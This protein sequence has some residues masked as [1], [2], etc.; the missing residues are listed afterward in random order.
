[1]F[2]THGIEEIRFKYSIRDKLTVPMNAFHVFADWTHWL[3]IYI[4]VLHLSDLYM[5]N[6]DIC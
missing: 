1:M 4:R 5:T 2:K 3:K 6:K